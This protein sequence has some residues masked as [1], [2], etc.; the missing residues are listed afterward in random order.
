MKMHSIA[1]ID[2]KHHTGVWLEVREPGNWLALGFIR[3]E[4]IYE[5]S[6]KHHENQ[7]IQDSQ[8]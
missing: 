2:R 8:S 3:R 4:S 5:E 6:L 1:S 7:L